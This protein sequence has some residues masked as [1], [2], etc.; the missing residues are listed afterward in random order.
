M[1]RR[2]VSAL[3]PAWTLGALQAPLENAASYVATNH[4]HLDLCGRQAQVQLPMSCQRLEIRPSRASREVVHERGDHDQSTHAS[5]H[6]GGKATATRRMAPCQMGSEARPG[7]PMCILPGPRSATTCVFGLPR[8]GLCQVLPDRRWR[9]QQGSPRTAAEIASP[10]RLLPRRGSQL[11]NGFDGCR[12]GGRSRRS[13]CS[14][15]SAL[16]GGRCPNQNSC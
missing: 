4:D 8:Q 11:W 5:L 12:R 15:R 6:F 3:D 14:R 1:D 9:R 13:S 10:G 16:Y 2:P 7:D